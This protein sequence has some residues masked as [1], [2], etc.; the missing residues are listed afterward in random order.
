[1]VDSVGAVTLFRRG[2]TSALPSTTGPVT[3]FGTSIEPL[4][5]RIR[6]D[7][8]RDAVEV[9]FYWR[10]I[11]RVPRSYTVF[12]HLIGPDGAKIDQADSWPLDNLYPTDLWIP[13]RVVPDTHVITLRSPRPADAVRVQAGLY[14]TETGQRLPITSRGMPGGSDYVT[15]DT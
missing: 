14:D 10:A 7:G 13:G 2:D 3:R 12:V 6:S 5:G 11:E 9:V 4:A 1:M 15:F 8:P